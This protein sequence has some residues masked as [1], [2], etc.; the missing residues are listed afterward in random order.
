LKDAAAASIWGVRAGN[1]VIV[2]N[3]KKGRFQQPLSIEANA[4]VQI[5]NKPDFK[6]LPWMSST[7]KLELEGWLFER[8]YYNATENSNNRLPLSPGVE[9]H[10]AHRD[11]L[12]N[13][14]RLQY[15]LNRLTTYDVRD[16]YRDYLYQ[17][18]VN[19]QYALNVRGGGVGHSY[20][21]SSGYDNNRATV[22]G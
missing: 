14:E 4:N 11:G 8:G 20:Y 16:D 19:Q 3:T 15:E 17:Q 18:I 22:I 2:V 5:A 13:D 12:V 1:G 6:R 9:W 10:I 7:E 21:L